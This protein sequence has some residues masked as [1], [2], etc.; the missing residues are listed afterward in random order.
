MK[1]LDRYMLSQLAATTFATSVALT[2]MVWLSQSIRLFDHIVNR[3][4]PIET[5]VWFAALLMPSFLTIVLP[6]AV[7]V[8][9]LFIYNKMT[10]DS[11]LIVMRACGLGH[12]QVARPALLLSIAVTAVMYA[13][14]LYFLPLS[15]RNFKDLQ[16]EIR[17][18]YASVLLEE[19]VFTEVDSGMV[20]YIG[21]RTPE[22][23]LLD[24]LVHD[25]RDAEQPTTTV[26]QVSELIAGESGPV[27][28][29]YEGQRQ[30]FDRAEK[31]L[32]TLSFDRYALELTDGTR[33]ER[34]WRD[35][36]ELFLHEIFK[37]PETHDEVERR[38][39]FLANGHQRLALPLYVFGY[40]LL[41]MAP[42]VLGE[43]SRRGYWK[44]ILVT[45]VVVGV[46]QVQAIALE[47]MVS[48]R[49]ALWPLLY[50]GPVVPAALLA[51]VVFFGGLRS[52]RR[53][54]RL[55]MAQA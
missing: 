45:V 11:E 32:T 35:P 46:L 18:N 6:V 1:S 9:V 21:S 22:G 26:A 55:Q 40:V 20:V 53:R 39:Q 5:F 33:R 12:I 8:S 16:H 15:F 52:K 49:I 25:M 17:T 3:G 44:R 42:F 34:N 41:G 43:F 50:V 38:N 19:G 47:D 48:S 24:V 13:I 29:L 36:S 30:Q 28:I 31:E 54:R 4:L 37:T 10:T 7:F 2:F 14:T 27:L 51:W 23:Q